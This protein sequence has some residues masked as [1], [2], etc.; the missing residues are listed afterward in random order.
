[1]RPVARLRHETVT[2]M[3]Y[4][5]SPALLRSV[6]MSSMAGGGRPSEGKRMPLKTSTWMRNGPRGHGLALSHLI[7]VTKLGLLFSGI[8]CAP[9]TPTVV[10]PVTATTAAPTSAATRRVATLLAPTTP[11]RMA[12]V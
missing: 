8:A 4:S 11:S 7:E 1:M 12:Q 3:E 2:S 10:S 5:T 9:P 6:P